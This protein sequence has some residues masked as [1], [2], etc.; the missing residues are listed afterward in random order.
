MK[1]ETTLE[2]LVAKDEITEALAAYCRA[3]DRLDMELGR[4][5]F[6]DDA[7][8]DYGVMYQGTGRCV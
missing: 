1:P 2:T 8:A 7:I 5:V 3:V 4:S 6:H